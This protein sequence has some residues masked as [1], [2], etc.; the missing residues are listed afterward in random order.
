LRRLPAA[1]HGAGRG[2]G[3]N[4]AHRRDGLFVFSGLGARAVGA[5][6]AADIVDVLPTLLA[7]AG[8]PIPL[9][10]DGVPLAS[11]LVRPARW[12]PDPLPEIGGAPQPY[13][14]GESREIA[15]RLASLG[16]LEP[17]R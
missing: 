17:A 1:Q 7:L 4:G 16:Y 5:Q 14:E 3:L 11:V 15:A 8:A 6:P 12:E 2:S 13:D 9:G 10:L